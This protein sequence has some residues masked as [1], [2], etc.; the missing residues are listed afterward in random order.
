MP[1]HCRSFNLPA[2]VCTVWDQGSIMSTFT[3]MGTYSS[4]RSRRPALTALDYLTSIGDRFT[5]TA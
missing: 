1:S 3:H 5:K 4:L 2:G